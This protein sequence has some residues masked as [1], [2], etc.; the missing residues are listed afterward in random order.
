MVS[1]APRH[2]Q[3]SFLYSLHSTWL[4][5]G[6]T[7]AHAFH[8]AG[9]F[10]AEDAGE[11]AL[12]VLSAQGVGIGVAERSG[13]DLDADLGCSC[14]VTTWWMVLSERVPRQDRVG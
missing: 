2:C 6:D 14:C 13:D 3:M 7:R 10:V 12:R 4:D 5:A 8:N 9:C 11:Q 1:W